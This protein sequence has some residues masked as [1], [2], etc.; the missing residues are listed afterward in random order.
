MSWSIKIAR[1]AGIPVKLHLTFLILVAFIALSA[2]SLGGI[3]SSLLMIVLLFG[4]VVL[5]ELGHALAARRYGISTRDITL[6][7]IGGLAMLERFPDNPRQEIVIA[8]A[9]PA[10]SF[11]LAGLAFLLSTFFGVSVTGA[12]LS[13]PGLVGQSLF[14][15][16]TINGILGVFNLIPALPMDGGR[17]FRGALSLWKGR[18]RAT[19]IAASLAKVLAV[20][21]VIAGLY[22]N[23]WLAM[24]GVFVYLG[25]SNENRQQKF[26]RGL[27]GLTARQVMITDFRTFTPETMIGSAGQIAA[28]NLQEDFPVLHDGYVI[29]LVSRRDLH[30][31][32]VEKRN[33][34]PVGQLMI[35]IKR[36]AKPDTPLYQ[37]LNG[38]DRQTVPVLENDR[39]VGLVIPSMA[40]PAG[41][42]PKMRTAAQAV[43]H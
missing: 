21:F 32:L 5:H 26:R 16:A 40:V 38:S 36:F 14:Y 1:L 27:D 6:L 12:G 24:I 30:Y 43:P 3:L 4:S 29:G 25:A 2:G 33:L 18:D 8:A 15:L 42:N 11:G 10:V 17:I 41:S 19:H 22:T 23:P 20:G 9:G 7:P 34:D 28:R 13:N 35:P 37:L 31:A 39:L